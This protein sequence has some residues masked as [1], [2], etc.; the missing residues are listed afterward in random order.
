MMKRRIQ[1]TVELKIT[2][3]VDCDKQH[4]LLD[5]IV[6]NFTHSFGEDVGVYCIDS[7]AGTVNSIEA[8]LAHDVRG[9]CHAVRGTRALCGVHAPN[10][11][12]NVGRAL[13]H[14]NCP[15][16]QALLIN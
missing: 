9:K 1:A 2:V 8:P 5:L 6:E 12:V 3:R 15:E 14:V 10:A 13:Q 7:I 16:C 11:A 4:D